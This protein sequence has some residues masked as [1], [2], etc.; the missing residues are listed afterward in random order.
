MLVIWILHEWVVG[1]LWQ[2]QKT[3]ITYCIICNILSRGFCNCI[4]CSPTPFPSLKNKPVTPFQIQELYTTSWAISQHSI[5]YWPYQLQKVFKAMKLVKFQFVVVCFSIVTHTETI[6][7]WSFG[8]GTLTTWACHG[9]NRQ[10]FPSR[11]N[12]LPLNS[13]ILLPILIKVQN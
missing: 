9:S 11:T 6:L 8:Q 4:W 2:S 5:V 12:I 13:A 10:P 7:W 3:I 1:V